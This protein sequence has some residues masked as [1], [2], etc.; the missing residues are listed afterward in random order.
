[1]TSVYFCYDRF[2]YL[3]LIDVGSDTACYIWIYHVFTYVSHTHINEHINEVNEILFFNSSP[4]DEAMTPRWRQII[5]VFIIL[6]TQIPNFACFDPFKFIYSNAQASNKDF[7]RDGF[8]LNFSVHW[9][10]HYILRDENTDLLKRKRKTSCI[11]HQ[12][13]IC[14]KIL[15]ILLKS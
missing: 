6:R 8:S 7:S 9:F 5:Y 2:S 1:M 14:L 11:S 15:L 3:Y 10:Y 4:I 12:C 13:C